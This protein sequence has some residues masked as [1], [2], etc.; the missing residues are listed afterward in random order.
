MGPNNPRI[1]LLSL[2]MA[3]MQGRKTSVWSMLQLARQAGLTHLTNTDLP[4]ALEC[5][6]QVKKRKQMYKKRSQLHHKHFV[7]QLAAEW[8]A[9][10]KTS[11]AAALCRLSTKEI[12]RSASCQIRFAHRQ[13]A[14][15]GIT[16][17]IG[18]DPSDPTKETEFTSQLDVE[19]AIL[20]ENKRRFTQAG[21]T[22]LLQ[23]PLFSQVGT[24]GLTNFTKY[25][26]QHGAFPPTLTPRV[27]K[28]VFCNSC[29]T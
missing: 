18:P 29:P 12:Q 16:S 17:V 14:S 26:L 22:P 11:Q 1:R 13:S 19:K 10:N 2:R 4:T 20:A 7:D 15:Q 24:I 8:A 3:Q 27:S 5:Q 6:S 9:R 25:I 28:T 21:S 23:E